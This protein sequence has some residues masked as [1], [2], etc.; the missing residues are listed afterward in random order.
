MQFCSDN[1]APGGRKR[2]F[3]L[4][5]A[6]FCFVVR[7]ST[8]L[9]HINTALFI[10]MK[11]NYF[12][13]HLI[14]PQEASSGQNFSFSTPTNYRPSCNGITPANM[15]DNI[16]FFFTVI[17]SKV[18]ATPLQE[19]TSIFEVGCYTP[20]KFH[21]CI[22]WLWW[23]CVDRQTY[24]HPTINCFCVSSHYKICPGPHFAIME[25][26]YRLTKWQVTGR[27]CHGQ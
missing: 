4:L 19:I 20:V 27:R 14:F 24:K 15:Q 25:Q 5:S 16:F 22:H 21:N 9:W 2:T 3:V 17:Y 8:K 10:K 12:V 23:Y 1:K 6:M 11:D 18:I 13:F 26:T 7:F